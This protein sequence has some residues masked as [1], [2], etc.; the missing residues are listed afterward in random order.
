MLNLVNRQTIFYNGILDINITRYIQFLNLTNFLSI[1]QFIN[2]IIIGYFCF[3]YY[4]AF[5]KYKSSFYFRVL[6]KVRLSYFSSLKQKIKDIIF[7]VAKNIF[8]VKS[9]VIK[10]YLAKA[11]VLLF[12]ILLFFK[13]HFI[14]ELSYK[15]L[16]KI[17]NIMI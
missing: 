4:S 9:L 1:C 12:F 15:V 13:L 6:D 17:Q 16:K 5:I 7:L 14:F 8:C 11:E 10:T 3:R 2:L